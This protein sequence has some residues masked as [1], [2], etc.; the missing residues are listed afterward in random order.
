MNKF[1]YCGCSREHR[2]LRLTSDVGQVLIEARHLADKEFRQ[3]LLVEWEH[4]KFVHGGYLAEC[5]R[6]L[7]PLFSS[8]AL[9]L[10][11]LE[12]VDYE[13]LVDAGAGGWEVYERYYAG[14]I[15]EEM[16]LTERKRDCAGRH[17]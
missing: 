17:D 5:V 2:F 14:A 10:V 16:T 6:E 9:E 11:P 15:I 12:T 8:V 3:V 4:P 1:P 7:R 13:Q